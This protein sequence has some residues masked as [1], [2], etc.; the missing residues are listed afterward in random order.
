[1]T[2]LTKVYFNNV[3]KMSV[4][5][6]SNAPIYIADYQSIRNIA[7][8]LAVDRKLVIFENNMMCGMF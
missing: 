4:S 8:Q 6:I 7:L 1:M 3:Y 5:M 2:K